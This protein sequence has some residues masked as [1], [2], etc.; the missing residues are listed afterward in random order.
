[1]NKKKESLLPSLGLWSGPEFKRF[2]DEMN[3][4]FNRFFEGFFNGEYKLAVANFEDMQPKASFPKVN[5]SETDDGYSV[6]IAVAGFSKED[7]KLELKNNTLTISA[8]KKEEEG[9]RHEDKKYLR[10]EISYRSFKRS[11]RFPCKVNTEK[12]YAEYQDGLI[13]FNVKK[14]KEDPNGGVTVEIN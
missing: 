12:V 11:V 1:M 2:R 10:Q 3:E 9:E 6:D 4:S 8:E 5:V 14:L 13:R 7:V